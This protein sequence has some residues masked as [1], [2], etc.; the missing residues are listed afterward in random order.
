V[1]ESIYI[2]H[3]GWLFSSGGRHLMVDGLLGS[4]FGR[5][6]EG[7]RY[8]SLWPPR[9]LSLSEFPPLDLVAITHEHEDHFH[10]PSLDKLDRGIPIHLSCRSSRAAWTILEEMGFSVRPLEPGVV[11]RAGDLELVALSP[12]HV[13]APNSDEWDTLGF[14][15]RDLRDG[16]C[17]YTN[18]DTVPTEAMVDKV[19]HICQ[20]G[21]VLVFQD[22]HLSWMGASSLRGGFPERSPGERITDAERAVEWLA[23]GRELLV[24][25]GQALSTSAHRLEGFRTSVAFLGTPPRAEWPATK[26]SW[27][28]P[29]PSAE[30]PPASGRTELADDDLAELEVGLAR[31]AEYLYGT[32]IFRRLYSLTLEEL[33]GRKPTFVLMLIV[34]SERSYLAFEYD[35]R[36]CSFQ[37]VAEDSPVQT[38]VCGLECWATD[39][40]AVF[41]G[42]F[43]PRI[44]SL[45]HARPWAISRDLDLFSQAIWKFFHPL[46]HPENCLARYRD[47][48]RSLAP[49]ARIAAAM[50]PAAP[51]PAAPAR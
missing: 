29:P 5:G 23:A 14:V 36:S 46:R 39:L 26:P 16:G 50:P 19:K 34:D 31:F 24:C 43:E 41:R 21:E 3:Q 18:V 37:G 12:D 9:L 48:L 45:G 38:Y 17:F 47:V 35:P 7:A 33:G 27:R 42:E 44:L 28:F 49:S 2:G 51:T 30:Y 8:P 25:P 20:G 1:L 13:S 10:L 6:P 11:V 22:E 32:P 4:D 15:V 40:L